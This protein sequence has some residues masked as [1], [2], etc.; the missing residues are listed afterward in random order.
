MVNQAILTQGTPGWRIS[1]KGIIG[2]MGREDASGIQI[3]FT[4]W[5]CQNSY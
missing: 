1:T 3:W 4:L 2:I 5:L